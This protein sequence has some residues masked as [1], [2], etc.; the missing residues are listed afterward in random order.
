LLSYGWL[1]MHKYR[2]LISAPP[3]ADMRF[4]FRVTE[5]EENHHARL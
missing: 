5:I 3:G 4:T 1:F 2:I